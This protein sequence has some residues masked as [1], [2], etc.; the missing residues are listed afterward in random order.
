MMEE[1]DEEE[2]LTQF[3]SGTDIPT[4]WAASE[5]DSEPDSEPGDGC[6]TVLFFAG[7]LLVGARFLYV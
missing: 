4:A 3:A 5:P 7:L 6:L 1:F 2:F